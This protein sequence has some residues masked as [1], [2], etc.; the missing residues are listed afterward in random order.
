MTFG[1]TVVTDE[2]WWP[3]W[4]VCVCVCECM[5]DCVNVWYVHKMQT[6]EWGWSDLSVRPPPICLPVCLSVCLLQRIS[7]AVPY[8]LV[9]PVKLQVR[10]SVVRGYLYM[11]CSYTTYSP[12][13]IVPLPL[14]VV[15]HHLFISCIH[16]TCPTYS[17]Y[18]IPSSL[19]HCPSFSLFYVLVCM[20]VCMCMYCMYVCMCTYCMYVC[21]CTYCMYVCVCTVCMYVCVCMYVYV[22]YVGWGWQEGLG[23]VGETWYITCLLL[24][25][26]PHSWCDGMM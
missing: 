12:V 1:L 19:F 5:I 18:T 23:A 26:C 16:V 7:D 6:V 8:R 10:I 13:F 15:Y 24:Q 4:R 2:T 9:Y 3:V 17:T 14:H 25:L 11:Q 22:L 20:Y 21:M